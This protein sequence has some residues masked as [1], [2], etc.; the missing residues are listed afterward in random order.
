MFF[1][2]FT[3]PA[4]RRPRRAQRQRVTPPPRQ[5]TVTPPRHQ[6]VVTAVLLF[7]WLALMVFGG[8]TYMQPEWLQDL[9]VAGRSYSA[10]TLRRFGDDFY[11]QGDYAMAAGQYVKALERAPDQVHARLHWALCLD[12]MGNTE[13]ATSTLKDMLQKDTS[14][15]ER[16]SILLNLG[17][18]SAKQG[19]LQQAIGHLEQAVG[20]TLDQRELLDELASLYL[21]AERFEDARAVLEKALASQLDVTLP[22]RSML[23]RNLEDSKADEARRTAIQEMLS[24]ELGPD[25]LTRYDLQTV[26]RV[27]QSDART[28]EIHNRLSYAYL[29][30]GRLTEAAEHMHKALEILP[31]NEEAKRNLAILQQA[32]SAIRETGDPQP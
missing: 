4:R 11:R 24:R 22:Y 1:F 5:Q 3:T 28:A 10:D 15:T 2:C 20:L 6:T 29:R 18:L 9:A 8:L 32:Q 19:D 26:R 27:Q 31:D 12:K 21:G 23:Q 7:L 14:R 25:Q 13:Q 30:L 16:E 17:M